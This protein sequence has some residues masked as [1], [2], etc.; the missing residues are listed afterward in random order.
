MKE[1]KFKVLGHEIYYTVAESSAEFNKLDLIRPDAACA[2]ANNNIVYRS[3]NPF[4]RDWFLHGF[5]L[6]DDD[7]KKLV[8]ANPTFE[9]IPFEGVES[10]METLLAN[11]PLEP[12]EIPTR[13]RI[14]AKNA[15]G[16]VRTKDGVEVTKFD[17][18]QEIYYNRI[19]QLAVKYKK[20]GSEDL[21][22]DHF[23]PIIK[24][25]ASYVPFDVTEREIGERGPKKLA[26][27]FKLAASKSLA[28]GSIDKLNKLFSTTINKQFTPTNDTSKM[29]T[30]K[31][32]NKAADGSEVQVDFNVSDKDAEALG[33][34]V[35]EYQDWKSTQELA[36]L[37]E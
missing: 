36:A 3:M 33:W 21:A 28:V 17:E 25:L 8:A 27:R 13:K 14:V 29:F 9:Y 16:E 31:Y 7:V 10:E 1:Q 2:E 19:L 22:R 5:D 35:K 11:A 32:P 20:F 30:G 6:A 23:D 4:T 24:R 34:L 18:S 37:I 26:G 12:N 15:K